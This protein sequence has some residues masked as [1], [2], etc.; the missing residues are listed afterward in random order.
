[1]NNIDIARH[2]H[3]VA[4]QRRADTIAR[5]LRAAYLRLC[6]TLLE[7]SSAPHP[8]TPLRPR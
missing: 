1:M 7:A 2:A 6:A 3:E 4:A 5:T 8:L